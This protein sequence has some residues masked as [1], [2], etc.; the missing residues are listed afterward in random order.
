MKTPSKSPQPKPRK[1][2]SKK[3]PEGVAVNRRREWRLDLPL[4]VEVEGRLAKGG[5]F[6]ERTK[7]E[8]ISSTGAYF[9]LAAG[10]V[11]GSRCKLA[12][13]LPKRLVEGKPMRLRLAGAVVRLEKAGGAGRKQGVAVRFTRDFQIV[14]AVPAK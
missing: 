4:A 8:N 14:P 9:R 5:R 12:I 6:A 1:R 2:A 7:L 3:M 10:L 13:D 11:V